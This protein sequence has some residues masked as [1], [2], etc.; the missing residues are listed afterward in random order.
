[1]QA[2]AHLNYNPNAAPDTTAGYDVAIIQLAADSPN[3]PVLLP[4]PIRKQQH[5]GGPSSALSM[6]AECCE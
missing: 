2:W 4:N 5:A 1:M 6:A 3:T